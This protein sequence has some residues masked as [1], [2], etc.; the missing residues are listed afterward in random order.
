MTQGPGM[1]DAPGALRAV[2]A[3]AD[4]S[5]SAGAAAWAAVVYD[6]ERLLCAEVGAGTASS[7]GEAETR[8]ILLAASLL[9]RIGAAGEILS[10][11]REAIA[12]AG[13][14]LASDEAVRGLRWT[15][16][17]ANRAA[18]VLSR[19]VR[20]TWQGLRR[21]PRAGRARRRVSAGLRP[22][23]G[24]LLRGAGVAPA[25]TAPSLSRP[26]S[27]EQAIVVLAAEGPLRVRDLAGRIEARW[28]D[29]LA[30]RGRPA[31]SVDDALASVVRRGAAAIG[32]EEPDRDVPAPG[33]ST[34][35]APDRRT[36]GAGQRAR[37]DGQ[38]G[39]DPM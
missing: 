19:R 28:P 20:E 24:L 22:A 31:Q 32:P 11:S 13:P 21:G 25:A 5:V 1:P 9:R 18:D 15:P 16:Q 8:A 27:L 12:A 37:T 35:P 26:Q 23:E 29:L 3:F 6:G 4:A 7:N 14:L 33:L 30:L 17:A 34:P 10:D 36:L 2:R 38:S 39:E